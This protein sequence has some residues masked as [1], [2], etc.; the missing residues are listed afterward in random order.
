MITFYKSKN[1]LIKSRISHGGSNRQRMELSVSLART[2]KRIQRTARQGKRLEES[3]G[4]NW[5]LARRLPLLIFSSST[6]T[7]TNEK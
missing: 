6:P 7:A 5:S 4:R 2:S 1:S 3:G